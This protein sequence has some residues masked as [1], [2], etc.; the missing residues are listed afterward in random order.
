MRPSSG[1]SSAQSQAFFTSEQIKEYLQEKLKLDASSVLDFYY[2][3]V[4]HIH[5]VDALKQ[6]EREYCEKY[7]INFDDPGVQDILAEF[8][9]FEKERINL[10]CPS[11]VVGQKR[12]E[13]DSSLEGSS[14]QKRLA[15]APVQLEQ[16]AFDLSLQGS[17]RQ[18]RPASEL[19]LEGSSAVRP[20]CSVSPLVSGKSRVRRVLFYPDQGA[21]S[22]HPRKPALSLAQLDL[23]GLLLRR[24][25]PK[26]KASHVQAILDGL[27]VAK[28]L[29]I[30]AERYGRHSCREEARFYY[31]PH[32]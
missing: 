9:T 10:S 16:L 21:P 23:A 2:S 3:I 8:E 29:E 14:E 18:K 20:K 28:A 4:L 11:A 24:N 22:K 30:L 27:S 5:N 13:P 19:S 25:R 1:A 26:V 7:G 15:S 32:R 6:A 31:G 12:P 17:S